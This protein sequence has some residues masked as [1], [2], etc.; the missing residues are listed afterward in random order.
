MPCTSTSN[1][2]IDLTRSC[3]PVGQGLYEKM[4]AV[5]L[6]DFSVT[7]HS[8]DKKIVAAITM[9][10][11]VKLK[12]WEGFNLSSKASVSFA[13]EQLGNKIPHN[14]D[15]AVLEN[16][17]AADAE[18]DSLAGMIDLV[19]IAKQNGATGRWKMWG[20]P[21]GMKTTALSADSNDANNPGA[22]LLSFSAP[23]S[24]A[25]PL[26]VQH[27]TSSLDDTEAYLETLSTPLV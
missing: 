13:E 19:V 25:T 26:T 10:G 18:V 22:F 16:T 9:K 27:I 14:F 4:Y 12:R 2:A 7:Y 23:Q 3:D 11:G 17:T 21:T 5:R 24:R 8:T 15:F 6:K 20:Y 1:L